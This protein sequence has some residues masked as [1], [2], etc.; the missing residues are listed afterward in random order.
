MLKI[1]GLILV[2][3]VLLVAIIFTAVMGDVA[4][5][6]NTTWALTT[7]ADAASPITL[8]V[9]LDLNDNV[10][11]RWGTGHD[12][13]ASYDGTNFLLNPKAVGSGEMRVMYGA[14][15]VTPADALVLWNG[16][17]AAAGAQQYSGGLGFHS[18]GWKT[19][20]TAGSQNT[21][22]R[23]Y[24]VPVQGAANPTS[25]L[26]FD[27]SINDAAFG[28]RLRLNSDGSVTFT[29]ALDIGAQTMRGNNNSTLLQG[30]NAVGSAWVGIVSLNASDQVAFGADLAAS[31]VGGLLTASSGITIANAASLR[32]PS[33]DGA[34]LLFTAYNT[35]GGS[36]TVAQITGNATVSSSTFDIAKGRLTGALIMPASA[37]GLVA[38]TDNSGYY[39]AGGPGAAGDGALLQLTGAN[40][41]D[42]GRFAFYTP[43]A[44]KDD[45][46][47]RLTISGSATTA[48]ATWANIT[49]TGIVLSGNLKYNAESTGVGVTALGTNSPAVDAT[50]IHTWLTVLAPDGD[51]VYIPAWK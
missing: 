50:T 18:E 29:G 14:V 38:A 31:T 15:G 7:L 24:N 12:T 26:A 36:Q 37:N 32:T 33:T 40:A 1:W 9:D 19:N 48:V 4:Q 22:W 21:D 27:S 43:N 23:V 5:V 20:A 42:P 28:N 17:D 39:L 11:V 41:G 16:T 34:T 10:P 13:T 25:Y 44:A 35:A 8:T 45:N 30:R 3:P 6:N 51:T 47:S 46:L 2:L 49:H